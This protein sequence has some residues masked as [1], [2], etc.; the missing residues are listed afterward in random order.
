LTVSNANGQD[1]TTKKNLI[2]TTFAPVADFKADRQMGNAPFLVK[3]TDISTNSPTS[4]VWEF[5]DGTSSY[6]QNPQHVYANEGSYD[7]RLTATNQYGSDSVFKSG[8]TTPVVTTTVPT[9]VPPT[10]VTTI[11]TTAVPT[12]TATKSPLSPA[13]M[14]VALSIAFLA[15]AFRFRK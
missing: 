10:T 4:W 2:V 14:I 7:V 13:V 15:V 6:E 5:G 1:T 8:S 9:T 3:F 11:V 12:T